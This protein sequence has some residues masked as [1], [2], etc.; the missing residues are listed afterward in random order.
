MDFSI[1]LL[2]VKLLPGFTRGLYSFDI[3]EF[4][5]TQS[6]SQPQGA[7]SINYILGGFAGL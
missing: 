2:C 4:L 7:N 6:V 5:T 1:F 3:M